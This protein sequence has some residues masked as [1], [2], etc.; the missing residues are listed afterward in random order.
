MTAVDSAIWTSR[1]AAADGCGY[2]Y[3]IQFDTDVA[4]V[5]IT[6]DPTARMAQHISEAAAYRVQL[7]SAWFSAPHADYATHETVLLTLASAQKLGVRTR[8]EYFHGADFSDMVDLARHVCN[9]EATL[10][11]SAKALTKAQTV[12]CMRSTGE[13]VEGVQYRLSHNGDWDLGIH[14]TRWF[15]D[16]DYIERRAGQ[17]RTR[18]IGVEISEQRFNEL[19]IEAHRRIGIDWP[20]P[21]RLIRL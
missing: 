9:G 12:S 3:V 6:R 7:T 1:P 10:A 5:G 8:R 20:P 14:P 2:L 19:W 16:A 11:P 21:E 18:A 4:K 13:S 17:Q 15:A